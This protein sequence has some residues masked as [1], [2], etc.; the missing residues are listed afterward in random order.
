MAKCPRCGGF[1]PWI[2][3]C[4]KCQ[5]ADKL[6]QQSRYAEEEAKKKAQMNRQTVPTYSPTIKAKPLNGYQRKKWYRNGDLYRGYMKNNYRH[7]KGIFTRDKDKYT[8]DGDWYMDKRHGSG[9]EQM[10]GEW[11]FTG[12]FTNGM[13]NGYGKL[14]FADGASYEG[15]FADN[16]RCG[17]GIEICANGVVYSGQWQK[18]RMNGRG[19][20][21]FPNGSSYEGDFVDGR[22]NGKGIYFNHEKNETYEGTFKDGKING[23][24]VQRRA[25]GSVYEGF[26]E[27]N[28]KVGKGRNISEDGSVTEGHWED[29]KF[30]VDNTESGHSGAAPE[31][32]AAPSSASKHPVQQQRRRT[33]TD[34]QNA[35]S[36][37]D[38]AGQ[39]NADFLTDTGCPANESCSTDKNCPADE[40]YAA[41]RGYDDNTGGSAAQADDGEVECD[42]SPRG[43]GGVY[44]RRKLWRKQCSAIAERGRSIGGMLR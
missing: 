30:I 22:Y 17:N 35:Q 15:E 14:V 19:K 20:M 41:D 36:G 38:T 7:G 24:A 23:F 10:P 4:P 39:D 11:T 31:Q 5:E 28:S 34:G 27:N 8:Y 26:F 2:G 37:I 3:V 6:K 44:G 1:S 21:T 33:S 13:R 40:S 32:K 29:D 25:D 12:T 42:I 9:T 43:S 18:G 16:E